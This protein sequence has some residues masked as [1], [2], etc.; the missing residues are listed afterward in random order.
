MHNLQL[1]LKQQI[2]QLENPLLRLRLY[3]RAH[4]VLLR[5]QLRLLDVELVLHLI[6]QRLLNDDAI[7]GRVRIG[8]DLNRK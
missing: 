5:L 1:L 7:Y 4:R 2:L 3:R 8:K 6:L